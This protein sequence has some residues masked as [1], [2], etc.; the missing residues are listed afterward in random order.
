MTK[1]MA[2]TMINQ[3]QYLLI[4]KIQ[5]FNSKTDGWNRERR[6]PFAKQRVMSWPQEWQTLTWVV[7]ASQLSGLIMVTFFKF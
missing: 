4:Q 1:C 3:K 2:N 7:R 6:Y 5:V